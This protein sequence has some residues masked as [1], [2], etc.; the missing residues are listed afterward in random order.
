MW[1]TARDA[2]RESH[3]AAD[4]LDLKRGNQTLASLAGYREDAITIATGDRDPIRIGG[5]I[6]TA[7]F[8][9]VFGMPPLSGRAF[10]KSTD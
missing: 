7:D 10:T 2:P 3:A 9:D 5:S 6:V 8:F 1:T 4:F